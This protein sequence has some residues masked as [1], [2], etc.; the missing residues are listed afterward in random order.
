MVIDRTLRKFRNVETK[1][2][3]NMGKPSINGVPIEDILE[4]LSFYSKEEIVEIYP[5]LTID[6]INSA[7]NFA[8]EIMHKV[9]ATRPQI[10]NEMEETK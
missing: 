1:I 5:R 8:A 6:D 2:N 9:W 3:V 10:F 4:R 7:I